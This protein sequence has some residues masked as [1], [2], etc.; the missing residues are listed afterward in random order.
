[1][2]ALRHSL[3]LHNAW[4]HTFPHD[5]SFTYRATANGD[6]IKSCP[7]RIYTMEAVSNQILEWKTLINAVP[8]DHSL[9]MAK[10][11]P[12]CAPIIGK[13]RWTWRLHT[14]NDVLL[15][16]KVEEQGIQLMA[17][18]QRLQETNTL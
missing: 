15:I 3:N 12:K 16:A 6:H 18:L 11:A 5:R 2:R 7:D 4:R 17:E 8:M 10:Y 1:M 9:V 13:G 14:L